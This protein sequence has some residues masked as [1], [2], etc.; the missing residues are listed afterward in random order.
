MIFL[1]NS[2]YEIGR[3]YSKKEN[4][5]ELDV[6][7]DVKKIK[8]ILLINIVEDE[9]GIYRYDKIITEDFDHMKNKKYL[10]KKGSSR[11]TDITPSSLITDPE[12]TF[13]N[14]FLKWF[15]K[16]E[17]D[18]EIYNKIKNCIINNKDQI[19]LELEKSYNS[20]N[21]KGTNTLLTILITDSEGIERYLGDYDFFVN[22]LKN[23]A[24]EKF[25]KQGSKK[26]KGY[27]NCLLCGEDKEV[28]GLVSNN[29]GLK[30]STSDK[31]GNISN[32][33]IENQWK[34]I[35]ICGDCAAYLESGKKFIEKYLDFKEYGTTYQ[36]IPSFLINPEENFNG[37]YNKLINFEN[38]NSEDIFKLEEKLQFLIKN[39]KDILEF[40][41]LFYE[42][43]QNAFN[44]LA[45]VE[46][47]S[48]SWLTTLYSAQFRISQF[49]FFDEK[50]LKQI[51][52]Q[53][54][55][56][57]I[58]DLVNK[59]EKHYPCNNKK[60]YQKFLRDFFDNNP[61]KSEKIYLDLVVDVL[62][63]KKL[64]YNFL[65]SHFM[66]EIKSNWKNI[67]TNEYVLKINVLKALMLIILF[68]EIK[69]FKGENIMNFENNFE[70]DEFLDSPLKKASFYMGVLTKRLMNIQFKNLNSTPFYNKL[71][72][73][74]LDY[75]KL[76]KIYPQII[77][78]LREYDAAYPNLEE[79]IS[80]NLAIAEESPELKK[81]E[82]SY[83][84]TL[85]FTLYNL[86]KNEDKTNNKKVN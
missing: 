64:D 78:K 84:F 55:E 24:R 42:K 14:K 15:D 17:D 3:L 50:N 10:Y 8:D 62:S 54:I 66:K 2:I 53:K 25:Y 28:F 20:L 57:N 47:I 34:M 29:V 6:L 46:S 23:S 56:G 70:I 72:G 33:K 39:I 22:H 83:Y 80:I 45:Y 67:Q 4:L 9:N 58:I 68:S 27:G 11:G 85:G 82:I 74:N 19:F 86:F 51:F 1:L 59:N 69:L 44:I 7:L 75:K 60:W 18:D 16:T 36:V 81:D 26:I 30:F 63:Q 65:L 38:E 48:P 52:G 76:K 77:N 5:D 41:F 13:N 43:N 31:P 73:L 49:D 61:K 35:P 32:G 37:I 79:K 40:K 21:V 71:Y 12:K